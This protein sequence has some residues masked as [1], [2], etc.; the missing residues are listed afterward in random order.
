MTKG[1]ECAIL[2]RERESF[3]EREEAEVLNRQIFLIGMP[4]SG[5]S[6]LGKRAARELDLSFLDLDDWIEDRAGMSIPEIFEQYGEE[7]FRKMETGALSFLTRTRPG[8]VSVG[9]GTPMKAENRTIMRGWGS[10]IL[11][12]RPLEQ[13]LSDIRT[14]D[15]PLLKDNPEEK[16]RELYDL[17]M[18]VYRQLADVTIRNDSDF[19][20]AEAL[21]VR[22]LRERYHA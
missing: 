2:P 9:G 13:I 7:G 14:E 18:P 4:G 15:R 17:R 21:L 6:T 11:L 12:D 19:Q 1:R 16:L 8:L 10:I 22:V 3:G 5:K 20:T